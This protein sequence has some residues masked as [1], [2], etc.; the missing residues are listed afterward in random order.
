VKKNRGQLTIL[1]LDID[2][3]K[4][5]NDQ[6]GHKAGDQVLSA[7]AACLKQSL[8]PGDVAGRYGGDEFIILVSGATSD[9]CFKV[10]E[11][12][13]RAVAQQTFHIGK[14]IVGVTISL[15]LAW[16]NPERMLPLDTL[17]NYADQALYAAKRQGR[18]NVVAWTQNEQ[19]M[20]MGETGKP[21]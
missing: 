2:R 18:N 21:A 20:D 10:A 14:S 1:M 7:V 19:S 17:I 13:R 8:R 4:D 11:R 16:T 3:F 5:V 9:Q 15:G 6:Y 12:I